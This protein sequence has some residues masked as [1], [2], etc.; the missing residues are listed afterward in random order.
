MSALFKQLRLEPTSCLPFPHLVQPGLL[1]VPVHQA[2]PYL[3]HGSSW[4]FRAA[5]FLTPP[6]PASYYHSLHLP[7]S[8]LLLSLK[9]LSHM[10]P[11][12]PCPMHCSLLGGTEH[13]DAPQGTTIICRQGCNKQLFLLVYQCAEVSM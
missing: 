12:Q 11:L 1:L 4:A 6:V 13:V 7:S 10:R 5:H 8:P 9:H 2:Q 3:G